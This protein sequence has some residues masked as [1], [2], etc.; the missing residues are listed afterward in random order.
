MNCSCN[1]LPMIMLSVIIEFNLKIKYVRIEKYCKFRIR[2][3]YK[4][5]F[6]G[7]N[8]FNCIKFI[9]QISQ[10]NTVQ[11][12]VNKNEGEAENKFLSIFTCM[13]PRGVTD[14]YFP[15][16]LEVTVISPHN[17]QPPFLFE[18]A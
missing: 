10:A 7:K 16:N 11:L 6:Y 14:K 4:K 15:L 9:F 13:L 12:F 17:S 18:I 5:T 2:Y 8:D 1:P 3:I